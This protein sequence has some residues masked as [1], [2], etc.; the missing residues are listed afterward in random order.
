ML[1]RI[2]RSWF[3]SNANIS[4]MCILETSYYEKPPAGYRVVPASITL[5]D[6]LP[7][8]QGRGIFRNHIS[9]NGAFVQLLIIHLLHLQC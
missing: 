3:F 1:T 6:L 7:G 4:K 5:S 8:F 2:S 9:Q